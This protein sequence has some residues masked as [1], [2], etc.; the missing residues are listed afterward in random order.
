[1]EEGMIEAEQ[2]TCCDTWERAGIVAFENSLALG[3][4]SIE[5]KNRN[6]SP[7]SPVTHENAE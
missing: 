3:T 6:Q 5:G 7:S 1:M 2:D 4:L